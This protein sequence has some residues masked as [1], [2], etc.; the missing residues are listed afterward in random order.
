MK[1]LSSKMTHNFLFFFRY[2]SMCINKNN[3]HYNK[4]CKD[5]KTR[6]CCAKQPQSQW[7]DWSPWGECSVSCGGGN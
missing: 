2:G 4:I 3:L 6:F 7:G 1:C 5:Y